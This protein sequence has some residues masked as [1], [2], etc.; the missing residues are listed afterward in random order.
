MLS[1]MITFKWCVNLR[2]IPNHISGHDRL[3]TG[4]VSVILVVDDIFLS[5][6]QRKRDAK[7]HG[8]QNVV[9]KR[10]N[11]SKRSIE[12]HKNDPEINNFNY[13][14]SNQRRFIRGIKIKSVSI[15][16]RSA[17]HLSP[18]H[19]THYTC[20]KQKFLVIKQKLDILS[21]FHAFL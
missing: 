8:R 19:N 9:H 2:I 15:R 16:T 11:L 4:N 12:W 14:L 21:N 1:T 7:R 20:F 10:W 5:K 18:L 3:K 17:V 13:L 6:L